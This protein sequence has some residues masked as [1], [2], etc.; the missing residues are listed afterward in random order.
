MREKAF[1]AAYLCKALALMGTPYIYGGRT[2]EGVD[3]S[4]LIILALYEATG[5][6][7][8]LRSWWSDKIW[9]E[10]APTETPKP[11]DLAFYGGKRPEDVEHV[12]MVLIPPETE[13]MGGGLVFGACD[14]DSSVT[15]AE[16]ARKRRAYVKPKALV[17]YGPDFRG[18][19]SIAKFLA[20]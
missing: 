12:M 14:G 6:G 20:D 18:Y 8:D 3:C 4:G 2:R 7:L 11:G 9:N 10:L 5:Y 16:I 17:K 1:R 15:D 13:S 19:R